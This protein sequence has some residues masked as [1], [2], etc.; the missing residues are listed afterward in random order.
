MSEKRY[1]CGTPGC[2]D[3][4]CTVDP[5]EGESKFG[6]GTAERTLADHL[7]AEGFGG[8]VNVDEIVDEVKRM[9]WTWSPLGK[10]DAD[11]RAA[12]NSEG[13]EA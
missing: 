12:K 13:N 2:D 10:T 4:E 6:P 11:L 9:G 5:P 8:W 7:D 3:P 1:P